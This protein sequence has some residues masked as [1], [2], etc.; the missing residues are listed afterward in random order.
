MPTR[1]RPTQCPKK[2]ASRLTISDS[3]TALSSARECERD[4]CATRSNANGSL[5]QVHVH[6]DQVVTKERP[7]TYHVCVNP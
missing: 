6:A 1:S 5:L 7:I 2:V 3:G 4:S